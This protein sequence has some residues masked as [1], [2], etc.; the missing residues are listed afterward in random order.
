MAME[1]VTVTTTV[2]HW[3]KF[4]RVMREVGDTY[5]VDEGRAGRLAR[6]GYIEADG[7]KTGQPGITSA[8]FA[9]GAETAR[10]PVTEKG[11]SREEVTPEAEKLTATKINSMNRAELEMAASD[12][13]VEVAEI[14]G[15][16]E[17]G[18]VTVDDLKDA[19]K[20]KL[21]EISEDD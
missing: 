18:F 20:E 3:D 15:S 12:L 21:A 11:V 6:A 5:E 19:L 13:E 7:Y 17:D 1:M 8:A 2:R 14:E 10:N 16:G 9:P 4:A